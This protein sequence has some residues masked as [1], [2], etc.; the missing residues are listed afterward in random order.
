M[1][2]VVLFSL[3]VRR[4]PLSDRLAVGVEG[5]AT[6]PAHDRTHYRGNYK[7]RATAVRNAANADPLT[8]CWR[9]GKT[10]D[11][12]KPGDLWQAGHI[13]DGDYT[14]PL[15]PEARSCNARAGAARQRALR[16]PKS[17]PW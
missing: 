14:S 3:L 17:Q 16:E 1:G 2:S 15:L 9:C 11:Q 4:V 10:L 8:R 5:V 6:V 12:H 13:R 7:V